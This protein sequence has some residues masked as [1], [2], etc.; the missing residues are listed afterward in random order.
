M[1][2]IKFQII[3]LLNILLAT[4]QYVNAKEYRGIVP[5][6][7][8]REDV[9]RLLGKSPDENKIRAN[10]NL[11]TERVYIVYSGGLDAKYHECVKHLPH[12]T[13]MI[14]QVT[15]K[16]ELQLS[17]LQFDEKRFRKFDPSSPSGIGYEGYID[18]DEG[19]V[20]RTLKGKIDQINYVAAKKDR[21]L[22]LS[23][24]ENPEESVRIFVDFIRPETINES[25]TNTEIKMIIDNFLIQLVGNPTAKGVIINY[26]NEKEIASR[27]AKI[28]KAIKNRKF[29]LSRVEF[30]K[31]ASSKRIKTE[32]HLVPAGAEL[33]MLRP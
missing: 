16:T 24:Y 14:I 21:N 22:C 2:K 13:V 23:Y 5:F 33:P 19:I 28:I 30:I 29:D 18:D 4:A 31:G 27:K 17:D 11:E 8:T 20:I 6:H 1:I 26:G 3:F 12:D 7:S 15:P 32:L 25:S 10:Y 9:T